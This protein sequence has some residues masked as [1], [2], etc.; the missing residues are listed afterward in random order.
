MKKFI[1]LFF[2]F[3]S[4]SIHAEENTT[5]PKIGN[6]WIDAATRYNLDPWLLYSV[7]WTESNLNPNA[8]NGNTNK[9]MDIGLMQIN[10][11][12]LPKLRTMGIEREHLFDPCTSI[13]VGAWILAHN[14]AR[15]GFSWKAIGAY[16]ATK[17]HLQI[18]Y[19][20]K[21]YHNYNWFTKKALEAQMEAVKNG[22]EIVLE[23]PMAYR[24]K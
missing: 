19:A 14:F 5:R 1:L 17:E 8:T 21:V 15:F 7:A 16:N 10:S 6:C 22:K 2:V 20:N 23:N 13:H 18:K 4:M 3:F 9:T 11:W 12:W 24:R